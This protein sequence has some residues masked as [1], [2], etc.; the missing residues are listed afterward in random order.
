VATAGAGLAEL[1][2]SAARLF[3]PG[4]C[5]FCG[6]A[7][8]EGRAW[9]RGCNRRIPRLESPI[10]PACSLPLPAGTNHLCQECLK[11]RPPFEKTLALLVYE[12]LAASLVQEIKY[13]CHLFLLRNLLAEDPGIWKHISDYA[14]GADMIVPVPL[15][16]GRLLKRGYNQSLL[17]AKTVFGRTTVRID[18]FALERIRRTASQTGMNGAERRK[19]LRNAFAADRKR[20]RGK[21]I[22][23]VDDVMTTGTTA[24]ECSRTL[25]RDGASGVRVFALARTP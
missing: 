24:A 5:F 2:E 14:R 15:H 1:L 19:N 22:I 16:R 12:D 25:I 8:D 18:P 9:C 6:A 11:K 20:V 3:D 4:D 13:N 23:L 7:V 10:C 17:I 21:N